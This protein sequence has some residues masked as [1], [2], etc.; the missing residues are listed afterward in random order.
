[1][2]NC[3][4]ERERESGSETGKMTKCADTQTEKQSEKNCIA[5]A[6]FAFVHFIRFLV[7][8]TIHN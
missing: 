3:N 5:T 2:D 6:I 7:M 8:G 1:M 4:T